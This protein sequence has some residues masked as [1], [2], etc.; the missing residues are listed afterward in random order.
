[1]IISVDA[2]KAFYRIQHQFLIKTTS[3]LRIEDNFLNMTKVN[4]IKKT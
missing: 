2:E 1:M 3:K 4:M